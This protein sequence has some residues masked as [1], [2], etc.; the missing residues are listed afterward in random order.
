MVGAFADGTIG[1]ITPIEDR[2]KLW[3][4]TYGKEFDKYLVR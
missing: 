1:M 4:I 2:V 3:N